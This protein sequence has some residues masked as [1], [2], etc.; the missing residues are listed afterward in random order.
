MT[1]K[2]ENEWRTYRKMA[3]PPNA[4]DAQVTETKRAFFAGAST[5]I[6]L[7]ASSCD[8]SKTEPT[9]EDS[10][11]LENIWK[12]MDAFFEEDKKE[13]EA[14]IAAVKKVEDP[15]VITK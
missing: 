11:L 10:K 8:P 14:R 12:E 4:G 3:V 6:T 7:L 13:V 1:G 2:F 9:D 5:V 15:V